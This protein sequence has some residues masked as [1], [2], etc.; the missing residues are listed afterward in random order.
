M[1]DKL[2]FKQLVDEIKDERIKIV[3]QSI[4]NRLNQYDLDEAEKEFSR[5]ISDLRQ[6]DHAKVVANK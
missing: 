4:G 1:T 3:L 6:L 2:K 5:L